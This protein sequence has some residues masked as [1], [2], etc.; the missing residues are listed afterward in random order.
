MRKSSTLTYLVL[1]LDILAI[2]F[3]VV[4]VAVFSVSKDAD[5]LLLCEYLSEMFI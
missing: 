4:S 3:S 1:K 2:V 5:F